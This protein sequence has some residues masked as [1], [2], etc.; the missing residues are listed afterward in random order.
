[1]D[2]TGKS[3]IVTGAGQGIGR[4]LANA[5]ASEG[6]RILGSELSGERA[7]RVAREIGG[8]A[9]V[10]DVRKPDDI[11]A[12]TAAAEATFG[13]V[14]IQV[15]N[16]G[17]ALGEHDG[18]TSQPDAHWQNSWDVHVMAHLRASRLL[19]PQMIARGSGVLVNVAAA[20]GLLSQ[21]GDATYSST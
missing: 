14:D 4:A 18:A 20:A 10:G 19:L 11:A 17:F 9:H 15:S 5:L 16:A 12:M 6:A 13:S 1:M 7:E 2:F 8:V 3:A 21:I